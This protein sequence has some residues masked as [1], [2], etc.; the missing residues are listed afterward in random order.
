[1]TG[2]SAVNEANE[3]KAAT[4]AKRDS[5]ERQNL[6]SDVSLPD[7]VLESLYQSYTIK[8]KRDGLDCFLAASILFDLWAILVP[9]GQSWES[10]GECV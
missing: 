7:E 5:T 6:A 3:R 2:H 8:Q 10:L 9:Q 1:M 4:T